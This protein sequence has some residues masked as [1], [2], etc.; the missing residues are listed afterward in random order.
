VSWTAFHE[1]NKR[2]YSQVHTRPHTA[3]QNI[4]T[5]S[6]A[7]QSFPEGSFSRGTAAGT[8]RWP[9]LRWVSRLERSIARCTFCACPNVVQRD[10]CTTVKPRSR[11]QSGIR[12]ETSEVSTEAVL[13]GRN[14]APSGFVI[15]RRLAKAASSRKFQQMKRNPPL[16]ETNELRHKSGSQPDNWKSCYWN[17]SL[18]DHY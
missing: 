8:W 10:N 12:M 13:Y 6:E 11:C 18:T 3:L 2:V 1:A 14:W 9:K 7:R 15:P 5:G 17:W 16:G 4:Q